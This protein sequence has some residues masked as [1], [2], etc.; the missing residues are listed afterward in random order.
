[1]KVGNLFSSQLLSF[2]AKITKY[3]ISLVPWI[4]N[5]EGPDEFA[6]QI[7][8]R[9]VQIGPNRLPKHVNWRCWKEFTMLGLWSKINIA[10]IMPFPLDFQYH[11]SRLSGRIEQI[12]NAGIR[13]RRWVNP[14]QTRGADYA[15]H[16]TTWYTRLFRPSYGPASY[17]VQ[18]EGETLDRQVSWLNL[19]G[20]SQVKH[21][22]VFP[23]FKNRVYLTYFWVQV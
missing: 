7:S 23:K 16:I 6:P 3:V 21:V 1:M 10:Y 13:G 11:S 20:W 22:N 5:H 15:H 9:F 4:P 14:N 17:E 12:R 19:T 2:P 8:E 18:W